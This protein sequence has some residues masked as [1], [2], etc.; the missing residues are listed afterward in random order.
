[1]GEIIAVVFQWEIKDGV[2]KSVKKRRERC[3]R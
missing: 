2:K 1:M 3:S